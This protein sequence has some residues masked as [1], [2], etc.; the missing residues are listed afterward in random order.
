MKRI[1][2]NYS[3]LLQLR[4]AA[5][6]NYLDSH[7]AARALRLF[8]V[9]SLIAGLGILVGIPG[10]LRQLTL[11]EQ[12]D[13]AAAAIQDTAVEVVAAVAPVLTE[14]QSVTE[15]AVIAVQN[16]VGEIGARI[17][18]VVAIVNGWMAAGRA[19]VEQSTADAQQLL[20][21]ANV[22]AQQIEQVAGQAQA[23]AEQLGTL[24]AR[25]GV[26]AEQ[27]TSLLQRAGV[28]A[29]KIAQVQQVR[30]QVESAAGAVSGAAG[31]VS[32]ATDSALAQLQPLLDRLAI[33]EAQFLDIL[34]QLSTTPEQV[35]RLMQQ[36][37]LAPEAIGGLIDQV[38]ATP[39]Q[40]GQL[41]ADVRAEAEAA[42]P[43]IGTRPSRIVR[44]FGEWVSTPL[45]LASDWLLFALLLLVVVKLLGGRAPLPKHLGAMLLAAAPLVLTFGL[46][47]PNLDSVLSLP[48]AGAVHYYARV[49]AVV[50][51]AWAALILLRTLSVA[52]EISL[53]RTAGALALAWLT[54][55]V[56]LPL[57]GVL[58]SGYL[59]A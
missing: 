43:P 16:T 38:E 44:L 7:N 14:A 48:M 4:P 47:I 22:T 28:N 9:V 21:Q 8:V 15:A 17:N 20:N 6:H 59:L 39:A 36:L 41:A 30:S 23:T 37:S 52:H 29:D 45:R 40:L 33:T 24:L 51:L 19:Q 56:L 13:V 25:A 54:F 11:P 34:A 12:V 5:I 32:S 57:A 49:L 27:A 53:W 1:F 26:S 46:Y 10:A 58:L 2:G 50:G 31:V 3:G 18:G 55:Y 42:E 35:N